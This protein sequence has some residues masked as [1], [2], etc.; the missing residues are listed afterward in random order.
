MKG[1]GSLEYLIILAMVLI[2]ALIAVVLLGGFPVGAQTT[3]DAEALSYWVNARPFAI[4]EWGQVNATVYLSITNIDTNRLV[5]TNVTLGNVTRSFSPG[6][7]FG[8]GA[9]KN[10]SLSGFPECDEFTY[11]SYEY[12]VSFVFD[13]SAIAGARQVGSKPIIGRCHAS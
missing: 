2:V 9:T 10:I 11:D 12:N 6:W 7:T 8:A 13:S 4:R 5:L 3:M 1:Q